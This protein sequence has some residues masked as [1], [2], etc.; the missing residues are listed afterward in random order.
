M[1]RSE[2]TDLTIHTLFGRFRKELDAQIEKKGRAA[3]VSSHETRGAVAEEVDE[4]NAAVHANDRD[5]MKAEL[6]DIMISAFWGLASE[7]EGGW[8]W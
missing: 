4:F 3:W 8:D 1:Q 5:R 2:V 6:M 7:G